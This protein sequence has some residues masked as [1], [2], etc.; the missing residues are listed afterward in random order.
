MNIDND[1]KNPKNYIAGIFYCN[2]NDKRII[3]PKQDRYRG[4]TINFGNRFTYI[5][6]VSIAVFILIYQLLK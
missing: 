6:L 3:V 1:I 5:I 2:K 4:W